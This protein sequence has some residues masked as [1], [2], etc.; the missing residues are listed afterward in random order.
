MQ[1]N[2]IVSTEKSFWSINIMFSASWR[3]PAALAELSEGTPGE[4]VASNAVR[5]LQGARG[6]KF[7]H[8]N[9]RQAEVKHKTWQL[10]VKLSTSI[11]Y[12]DALGCWRLLQIPKRRNQFDMCHQKFLLIVVLLLPKDV[13]GTLISLLGGF[14]FLP[15]TYCKRF[16]VFL[17]SKSS[18][19]CW[20]GWH[21][22]FAP[23]KRILSLLAQSSLCIR[24][25]TLS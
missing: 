6:Y 9:A 8:L 14:W 25:A 23:F 13:S 21:S 12:S 16:T 1:F 11:R 7:F 3:C 2:P 24:A 4:G 15:C 20:T 22:H 18:F 5:Q 19:L 17:L 10:A